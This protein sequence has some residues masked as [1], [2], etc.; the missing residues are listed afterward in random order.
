[1]RDEKYG[2]SIK[3]KRNFTLDE[4]EAYSAGSTTQLIPVVRD[5]AALRSEIQ[6]LIESVKRLIG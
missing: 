1:M 4:M 2:L 5:I 3:V 6:R